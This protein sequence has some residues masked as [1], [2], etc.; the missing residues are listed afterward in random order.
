MDTAKAYQDLTD[1]NY[2]DV[3]L[4]ITDLDDPSQEISMHVHRVIL[5]T[6]CDY[7][8]RL[9]LFGENRQKTSF[10]MQV[11]DVEMIHDIILTFYGQVRNDS[12]SRY[13]LRMIKCRD[14]LGMPN[15][16]TKLYDL[17]IT[18]DNFDLYLST[19]ELFDYTNDEILLGK[20]KDNLPDDITRLPLELAKLLVET[21]VYRIMTID[22][23]NSAMIRYVMSGHSAREHHV[24]YRIGCHRY[25]QDGSKVLLFG[26]NNIE[27]WNPKNGETLSHIRRNDK[28]ENISLNGSNILIH[29]SNSNGEYVDVVDATT[30]NLLSQHKCADSHTIQICQPYDI[31]TLS[32]VD[33]VMYIKDFFTEETIITYNGSDFDTDRS[34]MSGSYYIVYNN[35]GIWIFDTTINQL[36]THVKTRSIFNIAISPDNTIIIT[37][38]YDGHIKVW[39]IKSGAFLRKFDN[40]HYA[41]CIVFSPD[42][43]LFAY[44]YGEKYNKVNICDSKTYDI[45]TTLKYSHR[46]LDIDFIRDETSNRLRDYLKLSDN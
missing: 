15:D 36:L 42:G 35:T 9:F 22:Y 30:S 11:D 17:A 6:T 21:P 3:Q 28:I 31:H 18:H 34:K 8:H 44:S 20:L 24:K 29:A 26:K 23:S 27:I 37:I 39:D 10:K 45:I 19:V 32:K 25:S 2:T 5:A 46:I 38:H 33:D 7:F 16:I 41:E 14:F 13:I 1:Q 12:D 40:T 43:L 4:I